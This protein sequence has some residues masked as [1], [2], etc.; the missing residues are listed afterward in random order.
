[1]QQNLDEPPDF[2][3]KVGEGLQT[4]PLFGLAITDT[5]SI[6]SKTKFNSLT[7]QPTQYGTP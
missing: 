1:M 4:L 2:N 3:S 6:R 7:E 5:F